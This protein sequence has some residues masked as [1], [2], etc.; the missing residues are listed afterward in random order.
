MLAL[1]HASGAPMRLLLLHDGE[2]DREQITGLDM[3]FVDAIVSLGALHNPQQAYSR[4]LR[5]SDAPKPDAAKA[6]DPKK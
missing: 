4:A 2:A 5:A 1:L 3:S 6:S